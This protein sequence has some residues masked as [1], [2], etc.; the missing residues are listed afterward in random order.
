MLTNALHRAERISTKPEL[1]VSNTM[2]NT[3]GTVAVCCKTATV[4][5]VVVTST[6]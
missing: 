1:R 6:K 4:A 5:A 3:I 2:P